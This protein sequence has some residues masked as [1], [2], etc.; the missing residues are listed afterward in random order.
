MKVISLI[1]T[2]GC[3]FLMLV[4][5]TIVLAQ[6]VINSDLHV[7]GKLG[8]GTTSPATQLHVN[9]ALRVSSSYGY[10]IVSSTDANYM[11]FN[12][13]LPAFHFNKPL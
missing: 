3:A 13:N 12:T 5:P 1:R 2:L 6:Q 4:A 10:L 8:V 9:G 11:R 7:T